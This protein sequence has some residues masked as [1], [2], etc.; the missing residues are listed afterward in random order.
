[1]IHLLLIVVAIALVNSLLNPTTILPSLYLATTPHPVRGILGFAAGAFVTSLAGGLLLLAL[2][3]RLAD[4][5]PHPSDDLVHWTELCLGAVALVAA[6][7]LWWQRARVS[8]SF[9]RAER[10][11]HRFA[12]LA[13]V[14]ITAAELPTA[15]PYFAVIASVA[16][17]NEPIAAQVGLLIVFNLVFLGP[18]FAIAAVPRARRPARGRAARAGPRV[19]AGPRGLG[20]GGPLAARRPGARH[21]GRDRPRRALVAQVSSFRS[22]ST[23]M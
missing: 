3:D 6:G 13:G 12:P 15:L 17:S 23:I 10:G 19:H 11:V 7:V 18:V 21:P 20:G 4:A 8:A 9:A 14:T 16:A 22:P 2:G 5:V 1:M